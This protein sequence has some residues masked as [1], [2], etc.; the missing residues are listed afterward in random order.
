MKKIRSKKKKEECS[1]EP[2]G[3]SHVVRSVTNEA[4]YVSPSR[5]SIEEVLRSPTPSSHV[6]EEIPEDKL[7]PTITE[8]WSKSSTR[9]SECTSVDELSKGKFDIEN[10]GY[11]DLASK[12]NRSE[13]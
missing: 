9:T 4:V 11:L 12:Q 8:L 10:V 6:Y 5:C 1:K 13:R 7:D 3:F 2:K